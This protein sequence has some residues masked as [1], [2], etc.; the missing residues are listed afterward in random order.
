MDASDAG[1]ALRAIKSEKRSETSRKNGKN[2]GRPDKF[3]VVAKKIHTAVCGCDDKTC[4]T[5][6]MIYDWLVSGGENYIKTTDISQVYDDWR[7]YDVP[8]P[9]IE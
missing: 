8:D 9:E 2:G 6:D 1:K 4:T 3:M 7:E 5:T